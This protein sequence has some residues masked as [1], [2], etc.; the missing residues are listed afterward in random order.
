M[1]CCYSGLK[2]DLLQARFNAIKSYCLCLDIDLERVFVGGF[3][4]RSERP[5]LAGNVYGKDECK[6]IGVT[7]SVE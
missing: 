2:K 1:N 3:R 5:L 4:F 7:L 6:K